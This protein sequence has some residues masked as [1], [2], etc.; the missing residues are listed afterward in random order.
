MNSSAE[1]DSA[2]MICTKPAD[3]LQIV[4]SLVVSAWLENILVAVQLLLNETIWW[5]PVGTCFHSASL[6]PLFFFTL[7]IKE[8]TLFI[9]RLLFFPIN[10]LFITSHFPLPVTSIF[11]QSFLQSLFFSLSLPGFYSKFILR[12]FALPNY[13]ERHFYFWFIQ[14]WS[15][16]LMR[17]LQ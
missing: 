2:I 8:C 11:L 17:A 16:R 15:V 14:P 12:F 10:L 6:L 7:L 1:Q 4:C 5:P 13:H 3:Q 9:L